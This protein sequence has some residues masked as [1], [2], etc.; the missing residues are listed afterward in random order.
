MTES[1]YSFDKSAMEKLSKALSYDPYLDKELLPDMPKEFEDKKYMAEHPEM[2]EKKKEM[3]KRIEEAKE[4]LKNDKSLNV[5]F[6]RQ[7]YSLREGGAFGLDP[8]KCYLYLKANDDFIARAEERLKSEYDSFAKVDAETS[9]KVIKAIH[10]EEDKAN[11]GFGA[12]FG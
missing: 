7:E 6:T 9:Q 11:A 2:E 4:K 8:E 10:D 5:I 12:I 3:E 1:V